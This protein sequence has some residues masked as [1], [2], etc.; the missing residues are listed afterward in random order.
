MPVIL[1]KQV[2]NAIKKERIGKPLRPRRGVQK[3]YR[4]AIKNLNRQLKQ[5]GSLIGNVVLS[6]ATRS[7]AAQTIQQELRR[8]QQIFEAG[9]ESSARSFVTSVSQATKRQT[10]RVIADAFGVEFADIVDTPELADA[11]A[12][13]MTTNANLIKT[14]HSDY[15]GRVIQAVNDNYQGQKTQGQTLAQ[16]IKALGPISD[17]RAK[18]IARDQTSKMTA[19]LTELRNTS[20]GLDEYIWRTSQDERVVGAP[21]NDSKPNSR[22]GDHF[23]REGKRYSYSS[24]PADGNPGQPIQCRCYPEPVIDLD[25]LDAMYV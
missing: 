25:K 18:L 11:L 13:E 20:V 15:F 23:A 4:N 1:P 17:K 22:H 14:I 12:L 6:D 7:Q 5:A 10:E 9:A 8:T 2:Q 3:D 21:G 16:R 19:S 24:P